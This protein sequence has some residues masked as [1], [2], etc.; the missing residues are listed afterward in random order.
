MERKGAQDQQPSAVDHRLSTRGREA[1][2]TSRNSQ[3]LEGQ[4]FCRNPKGPWCF[5][6]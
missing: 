2:L 3:G 1:L 5:R 6:G 4:F